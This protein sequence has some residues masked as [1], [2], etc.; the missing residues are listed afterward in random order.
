[1]HFPL[2]LFPPPQFY[3][4]IFKKW[5]I[6][7]FKI[8][9][10]NRTF[11]RLN[12]NIPVERFRK[13]SRQNF[14]IRIDFHKTGFFLHATIVQNDTHKQSTAVLWSCIRSGGQGL[15]PHQFL[16]PIDSSQVPPIF[17]EKKMESSQEEMEERKWK[18]ETHFEV[19]TS[20]GTIQY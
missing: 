7:I 19:S 14:R 15:Q 18:A 6:F 4:G 3:M 10:M 17:D 5:K 16:G 1:M 12:V 13:R 9:E 20:C 11:S 2:T 8:I